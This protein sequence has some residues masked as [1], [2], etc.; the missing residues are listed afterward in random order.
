MARRPKLNLS[1]TY[2][3]DSYAAETEALRLKILLIRQTMNLLVNCERRE[4]TNVRQYIDGCYQLL[5]E[6]AKGLWKYNSPEN[7]EKELNK[8][9]YL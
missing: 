1:S 8:R 7:K 5:Y 3:K 4:N 2:F 6:Q 9:E